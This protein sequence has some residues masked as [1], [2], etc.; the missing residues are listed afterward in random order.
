MNKM[1]NTVKR[2]LILLL[3]ATI[4]LSLTACG[5]E[6]SNV[7]E[8]DRTVIYYA[9]SY[10]TAQVKAAY[11]EMVKT[12]ND[13]QGKIDG[14]YVE[15]T[16]SS[17]AISGLNSSLRSNYRYDV[18]QLADDEF[19]SLVLTNQQFF[20]DLDS[21][22]TDEVKTAMSWSDIPESLI[23]RFR[24]DQTAGEANRYNAGSGTSLLALPNG[25]DPQVLYYNRTIFEK[26][27]G[28]NIISVPEDELD[29]WNKANNAN[30]MPH[31]YAEYKEEPFAGAKSSKNAAGEFVYKVFN[32]CIPMNWEEYRC[33][34]RA[35][36][37]Q[38]DYSYGSMS[39]WWFSWG[40]S[41]GGDCVGWDEEKGQY[42]FTLTDEQANYL[43][44][45][46]ITVNGHS[47]TKGEVIRYE[48]K[49]Y[50]NK[51]S[52]AMAEVTG[53]VYELPSQYDAIL[54]FNRLGVPANKYADTDVLGYGVSPSTTDN[55][56]QRFASGNDCPMLVETFSNAP[57]L[58]NTLGDSLGITATVQYREY[59]GGSTYTKDGQ[60]YLKVIG[61]EYDGEVYNGDL[62]MENGTAIV[63]RATTASE[64]TGFFIPKNTVNENYDAAF[65]FIS[66]AAGPE[67]QK[68]IAKGNAAVPNQTSY[69][70]NEYADS[71]DRLTSN[72]W[73]GAYLAQQADIGDYTYFT[74]VAWITDWSLAFNRDVREGSM[75]LSDFVTNYASKAD[76][77]LQNMRLRMLGR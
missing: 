2:T 60:E 66:W 77:A 67:G 24:M 39:E 12:Y 73:A 59:N 21:Y 32:E 16:P 9:A 74:S 18:V 38:Y 40:W 57:S 46:D 22:L 13:T 23:N 4:V 45:D 26:T 53:K 34:S 28:M 64:A 61:E 11:D 41:V 17:G 1:K 51:N 70:L 20:I 72:M 14:V 10:V 37:T 30:L 6:T 33:V 36:Q 71:T 27:A 19:K 35:M 69:G 15:M 47:Y 49:A 68:I 63:G 62:H 8:D 43:A 54:E 65:K 76:T 50:M 25:S 7:S 5:G 75:L 42:V 58:K 56:T 29:A 44:L 52:G 3:A 55:R 31:G 48:D